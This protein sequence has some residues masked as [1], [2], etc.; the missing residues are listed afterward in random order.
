MQQEYLLQLTA[1]VLGASVAPLLSFAENSMVKKRGLEPMTVPKWTKFAGPAVCAVLFWLT[2]FQSVSGLQLAVR[3]SAVALCWLAAIFDYK[4]RLIPNSV[5]LG[6]LATGTVAQI[7][8][9]AS[10]DFFS[11]L[12]GFA[13]SGLLF[14]VPF[15]FGKTVGAGDV[16]LA[17]AVGFC[18]GLTGSLTVIVIMGMLI[19]LYMLFI[20]GT[21]FEMLH[22]WVP[23]GPFVATA[24]LLFLIK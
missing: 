10:T 19:L 14:I 20:K 17:A 23:M 2:L 16:K 7:F 15:I 21:V 22:T 8:G 9:C 13:V 12:A 6:L 5:V 24:Y 11:A 3:W 4:Y 1:L 18:A